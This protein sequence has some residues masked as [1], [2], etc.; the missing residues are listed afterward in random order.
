MTD[1]D[2][3]LLDFAGKHWR[4][5]G[6][7]AAAIDAE[8]GISITRFWQRVNRLLD[9]PDAL[10]HNPVVVNRLRRIRS[11]GSSRRRPTAR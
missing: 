10:A 8:F 7:H 9:D 3:R 1:E 6:N 5:A 2:R 4:F 11:G